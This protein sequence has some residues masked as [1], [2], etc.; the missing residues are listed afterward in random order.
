MD[1]PAGPSGTR[2]QT[3]PWSILYALRES[4]LLSEAQLDEIRQLIQHLDLPGLAALVVEK[5]WLTKYQWQRIVEGQARGLILGQYRIL[6]ELGEGGFGKV[7]KAV[8]ALMGRLAAVKIIAPKWGQSAEARELFLREVVATTR[9]VHPNIA[10]AYEANQT[11]ESLWFAME[12]VDGPNLEDLVA[13]HGPLPIPFVCAVMH[14]VAR[15]L[16]YAHDN[17]IIHRDIKPA[18]LLLPGGGRGLPP[19]VGPFESHG[20]L[21][22]VVD[23]G[24]ARLHRKAKAGTVM[25]QS[26]RSFLGTPDF[27]SPEQARSVHDVDIRSDLYSLGCTFYYALAAKRPFHGQTAVEVIVRHLEQQAEPLEAHR[28]DVPE[29]LSRIIRRLMAKDP[30]DRFQTPAELA[31]ELAPWCSPEAR[32]A[33]QAANADTAPPSPH[34]LPQGGEGGVRGAGAAPVGATAL[35]PKLVFWDGPVLSRAEGETPPRP[36]GPAAPE[37]DALGSPAALPLRYGGCTVLLPRPEADPEATPAPPADDAPER[38]DSPASSPAPPFRPDRA[39]RKCW[40]A[41]VEVIEAFE[42]GGRI[43]VDEEG[44]RAV[45]GALLEH[46]R[47]DAHA[48][49]RPAALER[50]ESVVAPWLT[51]RTLAATDRQTLASLLR[52]CSEIDR[53]LGGRETAPW[54]RW[55]ALLLVLGGAAGAVWYWNPGYDWAAGVQRAVHWVWGLVVAWPLVSLAVAVPA[56]LAATLYTLSRLLRSSSGQ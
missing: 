53:E 32:Q 44:Y 8:H 35:V 18:N 21:V 47:A 40:R 9:L 46:C 3:I 43:R 31:A 4:G 17:G 23:F 25:L 10:M 54:Q 22:K 12:Y 34:P 27:V 14:Q 45:Y 36:A 38:G 56:V 49:K 28:P 52:H 15:A 2:E 11:P 13:R 37:G 7:Y 1:T 19:A 26:E 29:G 50:I 5:E 48:G 39:F 30:G 55:V 33:R 16:H 24:L 20:V 41:W 42:R 6:D 51:P